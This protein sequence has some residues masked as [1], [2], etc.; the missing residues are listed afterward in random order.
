MTATSGTTLWLRPIL[1]CPQLDGTDTLLMVGLAD[2]VNEDD[3]CWVGIERLADGAR[4]SYGTARRRLAALEQ[5]GYITRARRRRDDG[6]LST[7]TYR[8]LRQPLLSEYADRLARN[9]RDDQRASEDAVTSAHPDARAE[10]PSSEVPSDEHAAAAPLASKQRQRDELLAAV[11]TVCEIDRAS[12]TDSAKGPIRKAVAELR[13]VGATPDEVAERAQ[14]YRAAWPAINLTPT[15]LA[16]HWAEFAPP[17]PVVDDPRGFFMPGTG[18][19]QK[20]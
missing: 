12:L 19:I 10:V 5:R 2:H 20:C 13:Q 17:V 6:N 16:R 18:W 7:Y 3:E 8:L 14:R 1:D 4:C 15:A 11:L 9:M